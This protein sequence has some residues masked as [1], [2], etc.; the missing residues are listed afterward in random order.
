M[1]MICME[2]AGLTLSGTPILKHLSFTVEEG[3]IFGFLG[4]SG[5]GKTTTI[6]VLT[7]QLRLTAG[8]AAVLGKPLTAFQPADYEQLGIMTDNSGVYERMTAGE[9]LTLFARM[10]GLPAAR[11]TE[12]LRAV[13]LLDAEKKPAKALSR[14]MRQRL[15]LART[16][17]ARPRLLF[18]DEPTGALDPATAQAIHQLICRAREEGATIF[19]TT[20][21]M[22]E[23]QDLCD[24]VAFLDRGE[25][26]EL[27]SPAA[28]RLKYAKSQ[29]CV[30]TVD[31]RRL[32]CEK[33]PAALAALLAGLESG[34]LATVHSQEP[35]L[36]EIFL[37]VTGRDL[38]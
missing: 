33:T 32:T 8:R 21:N 35:T 28:M 2:D 22:Q 30:T 19:L 36:R 23:A 38:G 5:A 10:R 25:I 18:L 12:A 1:E 37:E 31:G 14:G 3:E 7:R 20:H 11:V 13:D 4:P 15:V 34:A 27:A 16:L 24:R 9:N 17:L 29:V 26:R 6:K